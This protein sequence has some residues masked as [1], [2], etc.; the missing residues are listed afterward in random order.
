[1]A[2]YQPGSQQAILGRIEASDAASAI[3]KWIDTYEIT[4]QQQQ[5][6]LMARPV[7]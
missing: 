3:K 6:R 7:K 1:L 2:S 4:D 5:R